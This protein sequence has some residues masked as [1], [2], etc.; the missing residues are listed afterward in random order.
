MKTTEDIKKELFKKMEAIVSK[1]EQLYDMEYWDE[2]HDQ[3]LCAKDGAIYELNE[4]D[5]DNFKPQYK[6]A[7]KPEHM[8]IS[9]RNLENNYEYMDSLRDAFYAK[10]RIKQP[11]YG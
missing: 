9:L 8:V 4:N 3:M 6:G 10:R 1:T 7:L 2:Y 5:E 11:I